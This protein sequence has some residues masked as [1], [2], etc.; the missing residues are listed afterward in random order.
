MPS[1]GL[2]AIEFLFLQWVEGFR[3]L[4]PP[5]L[6]FLKIYLLFIYLFNLFLALLGLSC[7]TWDLL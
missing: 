7:G 4:T 5:T 1:L 2:V 3:L 6:S